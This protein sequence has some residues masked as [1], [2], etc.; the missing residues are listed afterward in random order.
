MGIRTD[1][2]N[3]KWPPVSL[4]HFVIRG[5]ELIV[6]YKLYNSEPGVDVVFI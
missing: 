3:S 6:F 4:V 2:G 1:H 5:F